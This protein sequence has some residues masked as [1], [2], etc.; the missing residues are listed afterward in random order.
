MTAFP[1]PASLLSTKDSLTS[2][3]RTE[4]AQAGE[5]L[6]PY[7]ADFERASQADYASPNDGTRYVTPSFL[8][9]RAMADYLPLSAQVAMVDG[10][11]KA[12]LKPIQTLYRYTALEMDSTLVMHMIH[13]AIRGMGNQAAALY[14]QAFWDNREAMEALQGVLESTSLGNRRSFPWDNIARHEPGHKSIVIYADIFV[15]AFDRA[16]WNYNRVLSGF[17]R[18]RIATAAARFRNEIGAWPGELHELV[19]RYLPSIPGNADK[20]FTYQ[21]SAE[22]DA[23][24]IQTQDDSTTVTKSV[25]SLYPQF[26]LHH[27]PTIP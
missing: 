26:F 16:T 13:I 12:A 5:L 18:L 22:S 23:L 27:S 1:A 7:V 14:W 4:I 9:L 25:E 24:R 2:A 6:A 3:V 20:G 19:P 11:W 17:D 21:Y 8:H 15:P 10:D